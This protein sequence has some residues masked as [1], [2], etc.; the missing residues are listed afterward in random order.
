MGLLKGILKLVGLLVLAVIG[1]GAFL[2][3]TDYQA[4]GT[5]TEKGTD[6]DGSFV[7]IRPKLVPYSITQR[8]N[9]DAANF[10]C[11]GYQVTFRLQ[12][13]HY[14]VKDQQGRLV[15]DSETGLNNAFSPIRCS[16]LGL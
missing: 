11:E 3:F 16:T 2:Y 6:A 9:D 15:Y 8:V 13:H 14:Q 1:L 5:I 12:T 10:V 7:V 4:E